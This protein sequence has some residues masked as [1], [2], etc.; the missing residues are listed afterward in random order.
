MK[1]AVCK[2]FTSTRGNY[3]SKKESDAEGKIAG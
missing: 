3:E 2:A 1:R